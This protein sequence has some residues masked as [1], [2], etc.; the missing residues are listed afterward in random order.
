MLGFQFFLILFSLGVI[1]L[2]SSLGV[3]SVTYL[4]RT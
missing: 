3:L 4:I 2:A 1:G